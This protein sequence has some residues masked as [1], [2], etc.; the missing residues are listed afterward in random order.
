MASAADAGPGAG[1]GAGTGVGLG[2]AAG[3][4]VEAVGCAGAVESAVAGE[5]GAVETVTGAACVTPADSAERRSESGEASAGR[6]M[7]SRPG[8]IV[9]PATSQV[10][11]AT[12]GSISSS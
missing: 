1:G 12:A 8:V 4:G 10:E 7:F 9:E 2:E 6:S 5:A 11:R 3:S